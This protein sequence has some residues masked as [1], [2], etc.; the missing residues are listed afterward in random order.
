MINNK[1]VVPEFILSFLDTSLDGAILCDAQ[2]EGYPIIWASDSFV[3]FTGFTRNFIIGKS[4]SFLQGPE[5]DKKTIQE[6][7]LAL[8]KKE[9]FRGKILNYKKD[10]T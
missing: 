10:G 1:R 3:D 4:C 2:A 6:I 9:S 8:S 5:T 7:S